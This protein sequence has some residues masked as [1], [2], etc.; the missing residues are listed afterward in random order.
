[1]NEMYFHDIN[2]RVVVV[3]TNSKCRE[4]NVAYDDI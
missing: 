2:L 3:G 4:G 1:M